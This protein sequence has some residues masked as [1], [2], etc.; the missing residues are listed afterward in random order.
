MNLD[1]TGIPIDVLLYIIEFVDHPK[2]L[3]AFA[4][5]AR[6]LCAA[7]IP[8]H[9]NYR[10]ISCSVS[11][12]HVWKHLLDTPNVC[13]RI[14]YLSTEFGEQTEIP[15]LCR[16]DSDSMTL[17]MR[18]RDYTLFS[19]ALSKMVNLKVLKHTTGSDH[20]SVWVIFEAIG[21]AGCELEEMKVCAQETRMP[22]QHLEGDNEFLEN[23]EMFSVSC[24][25][26]IYFIHL[27]CHVVVL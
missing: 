3:L 5:T 4:L 2:D 16:T 10:R 24:L 21:K 25:N 17:P 26:T 19:Q 8:Q 22:S 6:A 27:S 14:R 23:R 1:R 18:G 9:I 7:I 20:K 13:S 12:D 11:S 15:R